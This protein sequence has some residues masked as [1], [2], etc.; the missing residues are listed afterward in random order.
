MTSSE[1]NDSQPAVVSAAGTAVCQDGYEITEL[2]REIEALKL[3][4]AQAEERQSATSEI[5]RVMSRSPANLQHVLDAVAENAARLCDASDVDILRIEGGAFWLA[6]QYGTIATLSKTESMPIHKDLVTGR[7]ALDCSVVHIRDILAE[8]D[9]QFSGARAYAERFGYRSML[10]APLVREGVA[11]GVI[12]MRRTEVHP[13]ADK[14]IEL[15]K[16]FANQAAVAIENTRLFDEMERRNRDLS[17]AL[18]QLTATREIL[19]VISQS[20]RDV[21]PVFEAIATNARKLC[22]AT[23]GGVY[24]FDDEL[25]HVV[26]LD[27]VSP[28]GNEAINRVFPNSPSRGT[29]TGRAILSRAIVYIPDTTK[30]TEYQAKSAA[31]AAGFRS[32]L[33]VPMLRKGG[34][35][36][37]IS[38]Y[39][40]EPAMF[41]DRQIAMLQT[42]ADQAVIAIENTRLF[43]ELEK[44]NRDLTESLEQQTAT[45]E[46]LRVISQSQRDAQPVFEAIAASAKELCRG[47]GATVFKFDNQ[48]VMIA[49]H[50]V[51]SAQQVRALEASFPMPA[52][53]GS[54]TG[55]AILTRAPVYFAD[56][57]TAPEYRMQS[58]AKD[59]GFRSIVSVPML[60]GNACIGAIT[61]TGAEPRIFSER[62]IELLQTFADQAVIAIENTRL[63]NELEKRNRDLTESL[64]QQTATSEI[65]RV[66]S[67][68]QRD[69]QP[70]FEAIATNARR[71]CRAREGGVYTFDGELLHLAAVEGTS[72]EAEQEI[73]AHWR[74]PHRPGGHNT[75]TRAL[76]TGRAAY[77]EDVTADPQYEL[78]PLA[79]SAGYRSACSVPMLRDGKA[80]GLITVTGEEAGL[81]ADRQ[82]AMLETFADQAAI[83]VEN[84]RLFRELESRTREL[85]SS[86]ERLRSLAEVSQAVTST[87]DIDQV[88]NTIVAR[89]VQL[90]FSDAGLVYELDQHGRLQPR[91][92]H[93]IPAD[94]AS[95]LAGRPLTLGESIVGRA[96]AVRATVQIPDVLDDPDYGGR[97]RATLVDRAGFR[98]ILAVPLLGEG[99]L[100]GGLAVSRKAPGSFAPEVVDVLQTFAAQ[101]TLA[102]Q[103]A[104]LFR[105]IEQ[106][107]RELEAASRHKSE[108]LANMSHELR[109][110]LNAVIGFS[111]VLKEQMFG[112]L[113]EK[114]LEYVQDI[115]PSG[116]HL[117]SLINDILDLSK[118]EAGHME[119]S[120]GEFDVPAAVENAVTLVK[121]RAARH[122]VKLEVEVDDS[123]GHFYADERKFRQ[124]LLNLL[125][126]AVKFTRE[127]GRVSLVA[128]VVK[129]ELQVSVI[130]TGIGI[131]E[132]DQELI[133]EEFRQVATK[134]RSKP[135]GTGL[136]LALTKRFVEMHGGRIWVRSEVGKGST[137]G[138]TLPCSVR[139]KL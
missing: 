134:D 8:S 61:V 116:Q 5:L 1:H 74:V 38:V 18:E 125:S 86:V 128:E 96:A 7:A 87:L 33:S 123:L 88:L 75:R 73:R 124:I 117:L 94:M 127:G 139:D 27:G 46:I 32:L 107:G 22:E 43:N 19:R 26:A 42:F 77:I 111:E 91:A 34:P 106:K 82:I 31:Q 28:E 112:E 126:N 68:S 130:D 97:A 133:F 119:L 4:L 24:I 64:E 108:F 59:V 56:I 71:L 62:Q 70:V 101:S 83:A 95:E 21:Q 118:I 66:I 65:L 13:F 29:S 54:A 37:A 23:F 137:F 17:E 60:L 115:H 12:S 63:F 84:T 122:G 113:N 57:G 20:Q 2:R 132:S 15:L 114:Q 11:I 81:F 135:E 93:G 131:A 109:T 138:F 47:T 98:A 58:L 36:G 129:N 72:P 16:T 39:G 35:I 50:S 100:V 40:S 52:T 90:S 99:Q 41:S 3:K 78:R 51:V 102:I 76:A 92:T 110:P 104:R 89:A 69:V 85:A 10:V 53:D 136:G 30:D 14:Q 48:L 55:R 121:E 6:S 103:N 105:E 79:V 44:R 49:G 45:S 67:Q 25:L 120:L 9:A 80:F